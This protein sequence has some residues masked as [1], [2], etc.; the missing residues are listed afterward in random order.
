MSVRELVGQLTEAKTTLTQAK[1]AGNGV[2]KAVTEARTT[3]DS[4]LDG[5]QDKTL[6][7]GITQHA[8]GIAAE[9]AGIDGLITAIDTAVQRA[10]GIGSQRR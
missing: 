4:A 7:D 10:R 9:I 8:Q 2:E 6:G 3:V 1:A 5:V